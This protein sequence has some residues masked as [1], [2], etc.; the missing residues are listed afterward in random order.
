M[1]TIFS[2]LKPSGDM[3]I[4]NYL[5]AMKYWPKNQDKHRTIFFI[6]NLHAITVRQDPKLL[7]VYK[8]QVAAFELNSR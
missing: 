8:R 1:K 4:G 2:G 6:P 5:G 3:T 7:D